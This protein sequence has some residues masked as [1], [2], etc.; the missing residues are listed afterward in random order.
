[1]YSSV[2]SHPLLS[3][4]T[5]PCSRNLSYICFY[6]SATNDL[7]FHSTLQDDNLK[8]VPTYD[9]AL[10]HLVFAGSDIILCQSFLDP[11]DEI[12]VRS[13]LPL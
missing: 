10:L 13:F 9:E 12:P 8:F 11:T 7:R 4:D 3:L 5:L 1:M 6:L 2:L